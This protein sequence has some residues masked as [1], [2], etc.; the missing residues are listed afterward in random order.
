VIRV[1]GHAHA[2][3]DQLNQLR[4]EHDLLKASLD[5]LPPE[6]REQARVINEQSVHIRNIEALCTLRGRELEEL[7][8]TAENLRAGLGQLE[9]AKHYGRLLAEKE[10]VIQSLQRGNTEREP[11]HRG[12]GGQHD[13][14]DGGDAQAGGGTGRAVERKN[15]PA[16]GGMAAPPGGRRPLDADR[17]AAALRAAATGV[18]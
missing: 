5:R 9:L 14:T 12:T 16:A 11:G 6:A 4:S 2:L 8:V 3:T 15:L 13:G 7:K 18:G 1:H 10:S 17:R